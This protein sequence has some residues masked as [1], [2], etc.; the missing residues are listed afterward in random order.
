M[1]EENLI[2]SLPDLMMT[3]MAAGDPAL[4][5]QPSCH[6]LEA[7]VT[8][9]AAR[10]EPARWPP[11]ERSRPTVLAGVGDFGGEVAHP[12]RHI[13]ARGDVQDVVPQH[14]CGLV[15]GAQSKQ[16]TCA[17]AIARCCSAGT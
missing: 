11:C 6:D 8:Q 5:A 4:A 1:G 10:L 13:A 15:A 12:G 9:L 7:D 16:L 3:I 2:G 14:W 17:A